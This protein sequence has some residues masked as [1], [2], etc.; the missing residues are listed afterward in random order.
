MWWLALA[1]G[2][3]VVISW[4]L[5][6]LLDWSIWI[7]VAITLFALLTFGTVWLVRRIRANR[8]AAALERELL[9]AASA[10]AANASPDRRN[11]ILQLQAQMKAAI[12]SLKRTKLG[13][14]GGAAALYALPWYVVVG[15]P[16]AGKTTALMQSG[17]GFITP[18][19]SGSGKLRGTAGTRNCD[20]WFSEQA[21]LLDT[22]GRFATGEDDREEWLGFLD[23]LRRFR[24]ERPLE[25]LVVAVSAEELLNLSEL[26]L[27]ELAKT[28]RARA[29][30]V[31]ERLEMVLPVYVMVTKVDLVAGF[32][33]FWADL[34]K[35]QRGQTWGA[36][37]ELSD[38]LSDPARGVEVEFDELLK[39]LYARMLQRLA[40]E[41]LAEARAS[42]LQFPVEFGALKAPLAR[43]IEE[44][45]R[46]NPY[47]ETPLL[48]GFYL[49]SGTQTGRALDRVLDNMA[50]GFNIPLGYAG[51]QGRQGPPQS[52][53]VT[54]LFR[55]VIFPDRHLAMRSQSRVRRRTRRQAIQACVVALIVLALVIPAAASYVENSD[56][57]H[58]TSRDATRSL[59]LERTPGGGANATAAS[60][61]LLV[62]RVQKL[63][64]AADAFSVHGYVGPYTAKELV[65]AFKRVYLERLRGLVHGPVQSQLVGDVRAAGD[66]VRMDSQ[67]FQQ[68]YD[69]LKLYLML[70]RTEHLEPEWA[71]QALAKAWA[72]ALRSETEGGKEKLA[73]HASYYVS[74]LAN[75]KTW[76]FPIDEAAVARAQG[77]LNSVPIDELRYGWLEEAAKGSPP[78]RP[79]K[80]FFGP[81]AQYWNAKQ[82][83]QVPG[84][85]TALGWQKV[86]TLIESPDARL[87]L[88]PWVLGKTALSESDTRTSS[89]ER[90][91]EL[92]FQ[93]YIRAWSEFVAG[94]GVAAPSEMQG[95]IAELRV[96]SVSDG[97]YVRLFKVIAENVRLDV[98]PPQTLAEIAAKAV[99]K[100]GQGILDKALK[101][102]TDAGLDDADADAGPAERPIS[103]PERHFQPL[104]T[105]AFGEPS[106]G[107]T[108]AAPSGLS[109]YLAQLTTLEVALS[110]LVETK[111]EPAQEFEAELARTAG[112]VQRLLG[113]L[114][115]RTRLVLEPLL[116]NP[117]RGSRAGVAAAGAGLLSDHWKTEVWDPYKEKLATRFPFVDVPAE[118]SLAEVTEFF[119]PDA[120]LIWKFYTENLAT[121]LERSGNRFSPKAAADP[122]PFRSD[123]LECLNVAAEITDALFGTSPTPLV[124]FSIQIHPVS[125]NISEVSLVLDGQATVYRNEPERWMPAQW[126]GKDAPR[127]ATLQV[128]GAGFTDQIPRLGDFGLLRLLE[129][130]GLKQLG[131]L[132]EGMQI[133]SASWAL[134]RPGEPPVVI[135][136][137]PSKSV[138]PF[139]RGFFRRLKCPPV[140]TNLAAPPAPG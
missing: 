65:P 66:L 25:G 70:S 114:D 111:A 129:Q 100:K 122:M 18:P 103:P 2:L 44:L 75:D 106:S 48:R 102:I 56:L 85:Y 118:A 136:L 93:R 95:A 30:E 68:A 37:F 46:S 99:A 49:T 81:A 58:G 15:P 61:D 110:Q 140:V 24:P 132:S 113:G 91:R 64:Q 101:K 39:V 29:D 51:G 10:Q 98:L 33:E 13:A 43:F 19:G 23:L 72:R 133:L 20:W 45:C 14:R 94:L 40:S 28:L 47:Q 123:F 34:A 31:M 139:S 50:K 59:E 88:E 8:R 38:D 130:G 119:R 121:R 126:P 79:E 53:F 137:R 134:T 63:E 21:I 127:G 131:G 105:F 6:L 12:A 16:A 107:K 83:V 97:P 67:N 128:R 80:I 90:L 17:L 69:D 26:E 108:D 138:H 73:A 4:L 42:V 74:E 87:E 135:D 92:Y 1:L 82:N 86:R 54:E 71:A 62:D 27:E 22:A 125:A 76:A 78:I 115:P 3:F 32:V 52:Y 109:Q 77:R 120:G 36:S 117:I 96:L 57:I 112:S 60:L 104:L 41:P 35:G 5:I 84:L 89:A 116:M 124:P 11:E 7:A 55:R 9:R